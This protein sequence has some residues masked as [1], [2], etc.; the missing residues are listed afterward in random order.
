MASPIC[1]GPQ[2]YCAAFSGRHKAALQQWR[3]AMAGWLV[4]LRKA[5]KYGLKRLRDHSAF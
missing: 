2:R 1:E 3:T 4:R 5:L